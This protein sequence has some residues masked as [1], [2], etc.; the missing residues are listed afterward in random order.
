MNTTPNSVVILFHGNEVYSLQWRKNES[1]TPNKSAVHL[2]TG[3]S[4][5]NDNL[6]NTIEPKLHSGSYRGSLKNWIP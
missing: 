1:D 5:T 4:V 3:P 2:L 6:N